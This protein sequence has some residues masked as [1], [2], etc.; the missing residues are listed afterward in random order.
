MLT[1]WPPLLRSNGLVL[2]TKKV[3]ANTGIFLFIS[4]NI[5]QRNCKLEHD[6]NTDHWSRRWT[7]WLQD[8]HRYLDW[9]ISL[10]SKRKFCIKKIDQLANIVLYSL[11]KCSLDLFKYKLLAVVVPQLVE[12]SLLT[13][14]VRIQSSAKLILNG[15][16][17]FVLK[18]R[19]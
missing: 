19:K 9:T 10:V 6:S 18:R 16:L 3:R 4:I 8:N 11:C 15:Y 14:E 7:H 12:R 17:S 5:L 2:Y 13:L 1:T